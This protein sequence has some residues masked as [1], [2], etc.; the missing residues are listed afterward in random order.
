MAAKRNLSNPFNMD[1]TA[2]TGKELEI[3]KEFQEYNKKLTKNI[4]Y[5]ANEDAF[6]KARAKAKRELTAEQFKLWEERNTVDKIN[7]QFYEDLKK[8]SS[9]SQKS[10]KQE[11][12]EYARQQLIRLYTVAGKPRI[13]DM[14]DRV[15]WLIN[16]L[17]KLISTEAKRN[18][19][20]GKKSRIMEIAEW[21]VNPEFHEQLNRI[22]YNS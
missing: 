11:K 10:E 22:Y 12:Y 9:V 17:D 4:K 18:A 6:K 21:E 3:A 13:D 8:L 19:D 5:I 16:T 15:K 14:P 7:E 2:K 20:P 1:G